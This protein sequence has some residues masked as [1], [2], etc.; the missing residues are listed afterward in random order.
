MAAGHRRRLKSMILDGGIEHIPPH[1]VLETMLF[2]VLPRIDTNQLAHRLIDQFG[3]FA[4]VIDAPHSELM[5]VKGIG[6]E[7]ATFIKLLPE[8]SRFYHISKEQNVQIIDNIDKAGQFLL[9]LFAFKVVEEVRM[10]CLDGACKLIKCVKLGEGVLNSTN[11]SV[12][13]VVE[14]AINLN[15]SKVVLAHNHPFSSALPSEADLAAT[16]AIKAA[17][18]T[19]DVSL[20]DHLIVCDNDYVSLADSGLLVV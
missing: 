8:M 11:I 9:P 4:N 16:H 17:L 20:V 12:K 5:K 1:N 19:V 10:I 18:A 3:S 14:Y 6:W 2:Y 7:V 13:K 15:A